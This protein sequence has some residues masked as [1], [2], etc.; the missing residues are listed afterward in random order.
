MEK[1]TR[2]VLLWIIGF[3]IFG[4]AGTIAFI[5]WKRIRGKYRSP[6]AA[7]GASGG[8][9]VIGGVIIPPKDS[10]GTT[11]GIFPLKKGSNGT[12]VSQLQRALNTLCKAGLTVDGDFGPATENA[13]KGYFCLQRLELS[14]VQYRTLMMGITR[15][16][17]VAEIRKLL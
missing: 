7:G 11:P 5:V 6:E 13:M 12:E 10:T 4:V 2:T 9:L 8:G 15:G 17:S 16:I 14:E 1:K 3:I